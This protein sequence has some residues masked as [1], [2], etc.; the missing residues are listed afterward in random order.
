[1]INLKF[2]SGNSVRLVTIKEKSIT[3]ITPEF[4]FVPFTINLSKITSNKSKEL[5][6]IP[7]LTAKDKIV[8]V[9]MAKNSSEEDIS[10]DIISDFKKEGWNLCKL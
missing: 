2:L 7:K 4:N 3:L 8:I 6:K 1:M 9:K 5:N 10:K